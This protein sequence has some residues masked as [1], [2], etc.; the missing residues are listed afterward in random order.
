MLGVVAKEFNC[1]PVG[2]RYSF[3]NHR[4][5]LEGEKQIESS[6]DADEKAPEVEIEMNEVYNVEV[7]MSTGLGKMSLA[8]DYT[9]VFHKDQDRVFQ[10]R[11]KKA[12]V[13]LSELAIKNPVFP[14][15]SRLYDTPQHKFGIRDC[16]NNGHLIPHHVWREKKGEFV[17]VTRFTVLVTPSGPVR[18]T[19]LPVDPASLNTEFSIQ[20]Q[21]VM[22]LMNQPVKQGKSAKKSNKKKPQQLE[23][24]YQTNI[25]EFEQAFELLPVPTPAVAKKSGSSSIMMTDW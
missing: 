4:Y 14:F 23:Q 17:A 25:T 2:G 8:E 12:R 10:L 24:Q 11:I 18:L 7:S 9:S 19:G 3:Q 20:N 16:V 5:T 15:S 13:L 6:F 22:K 21:D 1:N